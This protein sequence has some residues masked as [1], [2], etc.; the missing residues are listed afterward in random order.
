MFEVKKQ[1]EPG[2]M[3]LVFCAIVLLFV[4]AA[5]ERESSET[6]YTRY[7]P[8]DI[9]D[10]FLS[11]RYRI[12]WQHQ[13]QFAGSYMALEKGFYLKR[14]LDV[15]ILPGGVQYPPYQSLVNGECEISNNNLYNIMKRY[16]EGP[17]LVNL[18]Q[19]SQRNSTL[20][21]AK[22]TSGIST[23]ND[24]Q[25]KRIGLWRDEGA[26]Y[27]RL[28]F[29]HV[30]LDV[31]IIQM[32]WSVNL[33]LNDAVDAMN[34]MTYNEYHRIL[35]SGLDEDDLVV[36]DPADYGFNLIEDGLYTTRDFYDKHTRECIAFAEATLE[37][38][39]YAF[40]HRDE[41]LDVVLRYQRQNNLPA[42]RAHQAWMLDH[43]RNHIFDG[44]EEI[45]F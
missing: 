43:M 21:V 18:A 3:I 10:E 34:A 27:L 14:G 28:F 9:P 42:N 37:G 13:A 8:N 23:L 19:I 17:P 45:G 29:E 26:D 44:T 40:D 36:F 2:R 12:K 22:K 30:G 4:F 38:W 35:M 33:L 24:M 15:Q 31:Q 5:C 11:I 39:L 20:L 25:G 1:K 32:D 6:R 16:H 41:T 7:L